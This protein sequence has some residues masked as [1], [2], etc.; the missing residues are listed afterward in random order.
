MH[1]IIILLM[2]IVFKFITLIFLTERLSYITKFN[3]ILSA[4]SNNYI[5]SFAR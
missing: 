5:D 1:I 2:Q 4:A 3:T